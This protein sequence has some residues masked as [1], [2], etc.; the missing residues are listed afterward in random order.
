M[1]VGCNRCDGR[2]CG[3]RT[4]SNRS[5]HPLPAQ[6]RVR[7]YVRTFGGLVTAEADED[8]LGYE[9]HELSPVFR[10][11]HAVISEIREIDESKS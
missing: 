9:R 3:A 8:D 10:A 4:P 11:G 7:F 5:T 1:A 6:G 2:R